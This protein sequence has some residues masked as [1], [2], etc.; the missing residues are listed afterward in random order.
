[1]KTL[2]YAPD[3]LDNPDEAKET[4]VL[5]DGFPYQAFAVALDR[6]D[7]R[8]W[9][10]LHHTRMVNKAI[11]G[12]VGYEH[13]VDWQLMES[14]V[15]MLSRYGYYGEHMQASE[16]EKLLAAKHLASHYSKAGRRLPDALAVLV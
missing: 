12:K 10:L 4:R 6:V 9:H 11:K 16:G 15:A 2:T 8:T 3:Q 14:A 7:Q 1:M 13:T 5:K